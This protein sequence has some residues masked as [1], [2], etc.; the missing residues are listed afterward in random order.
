MSVLFLM[1]AAQKADRAFCVPPPSSAHTIHDASRDIA[2]MTAH[3]LD[4][5]VTIESAER[6]SPP[7]IDPTESGWKKLTKTWLKETLERTSISAVDNVSTGV[8]ADMTEDIDP[9]D[10]EYSLADVF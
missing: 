9:F 1:E 3:L 6:Q 7:F 4:K 8:E 5:A 10:T 2:T